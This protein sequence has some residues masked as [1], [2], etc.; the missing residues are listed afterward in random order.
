[1]PSP[2]YGNEVA[3]GNAGPDVD[4]LTKAMSGFKRDHTTVIRILTKQ[5]PRS[6]ALLRQTYAQ[7]N[8]GSSLESKVE[9][10]FRSHYGD[11]LVQLVRGPL[12]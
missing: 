6:M 11:L 1:M 2:G 9:S 7:R 4:M 10:S 8:K 5:D 12:L 3:Q